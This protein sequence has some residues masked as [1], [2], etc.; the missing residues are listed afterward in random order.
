MSTPSLDAVLLT[1]HAT[2]ALADAT[3]SGGSLITG[4]E[5]GVALG[6]GGM[7]AQCEVAAVAPQQRGVAVQIAFEVSGGSLAVPLRDM[8]A[9]MGPTPE[10]AAEAAVQAW[11]SCP[12]VPLKAAFSDDFADYRYGLT[13]VN[14]AT[15]DEV[16]WAVYESPLQLAGEQAGCEALVKEFQQKPVFARIA[17]AQ[18]LP[19]FG[20][21]KSHWMTVLAA[22][23]PAGEIVTRCIYDG[24]PWP[25]GEEILRQLPWQDISAAMFRLF[26]VIN[27]N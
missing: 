8:C 13:A 3:R 9:G 10:K 2:R 20:P 17:E 4:T 6:W 7:T 16:D 12:F 22:K 1:R 11:V 27:E 5:T 25:A 21:D 18:A 23:D 19:Q 14:Q 26:W 24:E 15:G